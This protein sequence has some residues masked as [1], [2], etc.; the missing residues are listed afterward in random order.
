MVN[1]ELH[2]I[3]IEAAV[4]VGGGEMVWLISVYG[5][6]GDWLGEGGNGEM[7][8]RTAKLVYDDDVYILKVLYEC[9]EIVY[10]ETTTGVVAALGGG[11]RVR[12][13]SGG[14]EPARPRGQTRRVR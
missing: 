3:W 4:L 14:H 6:M 8:L 9:M 10:L 13:G 2:V 7:V 11:K 5:W 1:I 12:G